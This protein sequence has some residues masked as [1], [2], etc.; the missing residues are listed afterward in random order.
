[1]KREA[2]FEA[3]GS[4]LCLSSSESVKRIYVFTGLVTSKQKLYIVDDI[5][6]GQ[7]YKKIVEIV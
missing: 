5:P 6:N 2:D 3:R 1:M 7:K 4:F